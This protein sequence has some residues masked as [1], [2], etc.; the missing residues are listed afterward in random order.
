M[1]SQDREP[2]KLH[3]LQLADKLMNKTDCLHN[4]PHAQIEY[5]YCMLIRLHR[6]TERKHAL[7]RRSN[8]TQ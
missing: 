6:F 7:E 3:D 1:F 4:F 5:D 8:V 2:D